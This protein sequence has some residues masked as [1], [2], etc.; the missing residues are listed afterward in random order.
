[1]SDIQLSLL[2]LCEGVTSLTVWEELAPWC[3]S[4]GAAEVAPDMKKEGLTRLI[5]MAEVVEK[6]T[7]LQTWTAA[8]NAGTN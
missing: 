1:M 7:D 8:W 6:H 4:F 2:F 5:A 3:L